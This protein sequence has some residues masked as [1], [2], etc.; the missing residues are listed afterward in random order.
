MWEL[1]PQ[2]L[3]R[4][5][6]QTSRFKLEELREPSLNLELWTNVN[7]MLVGFV[8]QY[9]L[10]VT[11][12][13][14]LSYN[15]HCLRASMADKDLLHLQWSLKLRNLHVLFQWTSRKAWSK[16]SF[17]WMTKKPIVL[18]FENSRTNVL[19]VVFNFQEKAFCWKILGK[20]LGLVWNCE[21]R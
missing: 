8:I 9:V 13:Y 6:T 11:W 1:D 5:N 3:E 19:R 10:F 14:Q 7:L 18:W 20:I 17:C 21:L 4:G 16:T 2:Y 12:I 15:K